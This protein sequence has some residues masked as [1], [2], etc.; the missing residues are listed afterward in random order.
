MICVTRTVLVR[1]ATI[2]RDLWCEITVDCGSEPTFGSKVVLLCPAAEALQQLLLLRQQGSHHAI[3]DREGLFYL[4]HLGQRC[5][6][7]TRH[8]AGFEPFDV[9]LV[10]I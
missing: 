7:H 4:E 6:L 2:T 5:R 9:P 8:R 3:I 1:V 10:L